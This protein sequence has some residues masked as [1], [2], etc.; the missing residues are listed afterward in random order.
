MISNWK[1]KVLGHTMEFGGGGS[2]GGGTTQQSN[3]FSS[4][5][6]WAQPY[7]TSMLGAAQNQVFSST[8]TAAQASVA[9][10]YDENGNQLTAGS[11][12]VPAGSQIT[13]I[14]PYNA[15]G[16]F[17]AQGGQYGLTPSDQAAAN[18]S[19]AGF[20]PLQQQSYQGAANLQTP[21]QFGAASN[22]AG[23][24]GYGALGTVGQAGMY[25]AQGAMAGQQGA[26]LS[27]IYGGAGAQAGQQY[28][29]MSGMTGQQGANIGQSLGQ[30]ST[31][32]SALQAYMNPYIQNAL[33]PAQQLLNQQY[34]MQG[35]AQQGQATSSGAFGG[36]RNALMQ[37]LNQQ[38]QM[39]AQ[40]QLVGN[41]YQN[42]YQNAQQQMN[43]ANQ[44]ALAGNQQALSGFGQ[45]GSQAMQ[46]YGMGLQG[47]NQAGQL[48]IAGAQAGL[49]GV[50]AQQAGYGQAGSA[51]TNLANI[52]TGQ[53]A[54]QQ[55]ILGL[56]NQYGGQQQQQQ[57]NIINAGMTNYQ[58]AQQYP[59]T[60]LQQLK[61]L[62]TGL[63]IA[64][65]T[66]TAQ[67]AQPSSVT[68][69]AGLGTAGV[70]GLALANKAAGG[71]LMKSYA[72]GGS[73]KGY[74]P[75]GIAALNRKALLDPTSMS[76]QQ[77]KTSTQD[78]AITPQV[79]GIAQAIQL[80]EKVN[81]DNAAAASAP[82]PQGTI[83][84]ELQAK[85]SQMDQADAMQEVIPKAMAVLKHKMENAIEKGDMPLAQKY[86][87][88]L[89]QLAQMA[90]EQQSAQEVPQQA[91]QEAPSAPAPEG[92]QQLAAQPP[93]QGIDAAPSNLPEKTMAQGGIATFSSR[94]LVDEDEYESA[95]DR[96]D[97]ELKQL[98]GSGSDNDFVQSI[99]PAAGGYA[100]HPSAAISVRPEPESSVKGAKGTHKYE[101]D[102]IKE[103][104]RIGLDP[105]IAVHALYKETGGMKDPES[106]RSKAGAIGVMQLMP[107][108]AKEIGV[109][110]Y[111]PQE[112]ISGGVGYLKK[113][114][115]KYQDPQLA[116]MAYNA[117]PGRVDRALKSPKG[118]E[119][120]PHETLAYRMAAGG[121]IKSY[122]GDT[123]GSLVSAD[124][125]STLLR[126]YLLADAEKTASYKEDIAKENK[127]L[128]EKA[129]A[130]TDAEIARHELG[131]ERTGIP[132]ALRGGNKSLNESLAQYQPSI[133]MPAATIVNKGIEQ[134]APSAMSKGDVANRDPYRAILASDVRPTPVPDT[135]PN[136]GVIDPSTWEDHPVKKQILET[137]K[138]FTDK[139]AANPSAT[140]V[141]NAEAS[142]TPLS[143]AS[144]SDRLN[145]Y[146]MQDI[147]SRKEESK[148]QREANNLMAIMQAGF[149]VAA[150]KNIHPLGAIGEGGAQGIGTLAALRK[151][152]AEE[153]KDISAQQL[154]LYK[155]KAAQEAANAT[156]EDTK[157]YR[158]A[159][160]G[161]RLTD[162][163]IKLQKVQMAVNNDDQI[164]GYLKE[165]AANGYQPGTPEYEWYDQQ[166]QNIRDRYYRDAGLKPSVYKPTAPFPVKPKEKH[167]WESSPSTPEKPKG[168]PPLP[169]GYEPITQP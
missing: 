154:G 20:N 148:K 113:M 122:A 97:A 102:V 160:L 107:K 145:D 2:S 153:N 10:T 90:Q 15:Y 21:G 131:I 11:A 106:A 40:N 69:L 14:N 41:A 26:G 161:H 119:S 167:W 48:G 129:P 59:M 51:G 111:N 138:E 116:L 32:P 54:A 100:A 169:P 130:P 142:R 12:A 109:D 72:A 99:M 52:G 136:F 7:I 134:V 49:S 95:E 75:G 55:G 25:G 77:L 35:A 16:S 128:L 27:N 46:G 42:A 126:D 156:R 36:S 47:A 57:Q 98:F 30:M 162:E 137:K 83:M 120:L 38:N 64:D 58:T 124:E 105:S 125:G 43:A 94:G 132:S 31:S 9:P 19:V 73:V 168:P 127:R 18:A 78:G 29:G 157:A 3:Q 121:S 63:P 115:D 66:T 143:A 112:N 155:Y 50:G 53:L 34:G 139:Q 65:V 39:L 146:I 71:G 24:A 118:I 117:G 104:K 86:A 159:A 96:E 23:Q 89:Q 144:S 141:T 147:I 84:D 152:E 108:T 158:D 74:A 149:G 28:A 93:T 1:R 81:G 135:N 61:G 87:D 67:Q 101:Q 80:S 91:T 60:Q 22:L 164:A 17:N 82:P 123:D 4:I 76:Q 37:S 92:I 70:A 56:Q 33:A 79:G 45:A 133:N 8:P 88:E 165:R 5:S 166:I 151:Q 110:P 103:A 85:S 6:P 114:Y 163:E 68:Q 44:A 13:G 140:T 150:S 62:A